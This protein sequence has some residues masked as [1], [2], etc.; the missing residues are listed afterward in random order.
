VNVPWLVRA[1]LVLVALGGA[2]DVTYHSVGGLSHTLGHGLHLLTL[3][4]MV[5]TLAGILLEAVT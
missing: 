3:V 2:G 4:G 5:T 1:G